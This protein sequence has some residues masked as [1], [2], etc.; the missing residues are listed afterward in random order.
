MANCYFRIEPENFQ[1]VNDFYLNWEYGESENFF[2]KYMKIPL[3]ENSSDTQKSSQE[4]VCI[5]DM[6]TLKRKLGKLSWVVAD[7]NQYY[8][9]CYDNHLLVDYSIRYTKGQVLPSMEG[10]GRMA[11]PMFREGTT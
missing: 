2:I 4:G 10:G 3:M 9:R 11:S 5:A 8:C 6:R 7:R 1:T